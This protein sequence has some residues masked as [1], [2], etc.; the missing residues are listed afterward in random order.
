MRL[1]IPRYLTIDCLFVLCCLV[2]PLS[3]YREWEN[4][5]SVSIQGLCGFMLII[6]LLSVKISDQYQTSTTVKV[7]GLLC[8]QTPLFMLI[9]ET[10]M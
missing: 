7:M 9:N 5:T 3:D 8:Y 2:T 1:C 6:Q 10:V 4:V